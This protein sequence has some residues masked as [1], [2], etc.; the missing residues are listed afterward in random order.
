[1]RAGRILS[2]ATLLLGVV[3]FVTA[4]KALAEPR[5]ERLVGGDAYATSV[6]VSQAGW[7][8]AGGVVIASA[9]SWPDAL[10]ASSLNLPVLLTGRDGLAGPV[11]N[12]IR[13]LHPG[14]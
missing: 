12:E 11:V 5:S 10:A 13:R 8:S 3:G 7:S 1:M 9:T 4:P 6:A 14:L 2:A